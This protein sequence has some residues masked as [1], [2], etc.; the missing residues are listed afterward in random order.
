MYL[1]FKKTFI[2]TYSAQEKFKTTAVPSIT[3]TFYF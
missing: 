2:A 3:V 1:I